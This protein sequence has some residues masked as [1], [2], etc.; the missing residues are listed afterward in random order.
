MNKILIICLLLFPNVF[1]KN[2]PI[3]PPTTV[4]LKNNVY[5]DNELISE[6]SWQ[7]FHFDKK[8]ELNLFAKTLNRQKVDSLYGEVFFVN[9]IDSVADFINWR[10]EMVN[11]R[12]QNYNKDKDCKIKFLI[13]YQKNNLRVK[14]RLPTNEELE[15]AYSKKI[16]KKTKYQEI[17]QETKDFESLDKMKIAFRCVAEVIEL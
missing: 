5:I 1:I 14:C 8:G 12:I 4:L 13:T 3:A 9:S 10:T 17:T 2:K 7:E 6:M 16:I 15:Y 11:K